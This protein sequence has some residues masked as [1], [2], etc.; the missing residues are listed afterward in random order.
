MADYEYDIAVF[1]GRFQ[2]F[3]NGHVAVIEEALRRARNVFVI[4]GSTNEPRSYRNPFSFLERRS[5]IFNHFIDQGEERLWIFGLEDTV[6]NDGQWVTSIQAL[7]NH[8]IAQIELDEHSRIAL[9]GHEKDHTSFYLKMFPQWG[10]ISVPNIS[11]ISSTELRKVYFSE[12][13]IPDVL[14]GE[15]SQLPPS[16]CAFLQEFKETEDYDYIRNEYKFIQKYKKAWAS[17][18]Y[19]PIFV[20]T[21]AC[22]VQSSHVLLIQRKAAPGRGL[23]ALPGGF[24]NPNEKIEDGMIRELREETRIKVPVPVLKGSIKD[25]HVFDAVH[26]SARGRTITHGY[27]IELPA[28]IVL[29]KVKGSDDAAQ[30]KWYPMSE[31]HREMM[32]EDHFDIIHYFTSKL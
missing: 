21:D 22:V 16:T 25:T 9:I 29:P 8:K 27:L 3:H 11:N 5:V 30:A 7:V 15:G 1:V 20:T 6:Y 23:W 31:I 14:F 28:D 12:G 2:I 24:L 10:N 17:A 18:P 13:H 19:E 26:R 32:F 4:V